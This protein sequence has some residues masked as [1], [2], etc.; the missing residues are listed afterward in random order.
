ML[1][2]SLKYLDL[3]SEELKKIAELLAEE[4]DIKGYKSMSEDI[5]LSALISSKPPKKVKKVDVI[6]FN[7]LI[8]K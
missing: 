2:P 5:L 1:N 4:R 8:N 7:K 3:S 6:N